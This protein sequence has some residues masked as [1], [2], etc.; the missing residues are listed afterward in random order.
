MSSRKSCLLRRISTP[1]VEHRDG[2]VA[3]G[4]GDQRFFAERVAH[5]ELGELDAFLVERRLARDDALAVH[6]G[7]EVV[8]FVALLDDDFAGAVTAR[9]ACA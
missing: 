5:A 8:A 1:S 6:D 9:A 2:R 7:V 3:L 4:L